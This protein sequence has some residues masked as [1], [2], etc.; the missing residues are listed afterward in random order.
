MY[1]SMQLNL[2]KRFASGS[3]LQSNYTF[4]RTLGED[5]GDSQDLHS[6]YRNARDRHLDKRLLGFSLTHVLRNSGMFELPF[7]PDH[8]FLSKNNGILSHVLEKWQLGAI[9][10]V[11]SGAPLGLFTDTTAFN[12]LADTA[13]LVGN[14][15]K[16]TGSVRRTNNGIV[17]FANLRQVD[18]PAIQGLTAA[19]SLGSVSTMKAITDASGKVLLVNPSPGQLGNMSPSYLQGPGSFRFDVNMIK[20]IRV[21]E[22][23]DLEIRGDAINLLNNPQFGN[24]E[25]NINSLDFGRITSSSG[26]RIIALQMRLSF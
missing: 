21:A 5:E 20:R 19:Q 9:F 17:Y 8:K 4:S 26:E 22:G 25:T 11:F 23:K 12:A 1:H 14:L 24:P 18:D 7:G 2:E 16:S 13:R 6:D 10:N 3:I 15:P